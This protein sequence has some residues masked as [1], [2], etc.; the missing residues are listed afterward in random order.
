MDAARVHIILRLRPIRALPMS[1]G[2]RTA[3]RTALTHKPSN[4]ASVA[5]TGGRKGEWS[6]NS[7]IF[8]ISLIMFDVCARSRVVTSPPNCPTG[9]AKVA[10]TRATRI[11]YVSFR[12]SCTMMNTIVIWYHARACTLLPML[13]PWLPAVRVRTASF[14]CPSMGHHS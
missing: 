12:T 11:F 8:I 2:H 5:V 13:L 4:V 6:I 14:K 1:L 7:Y 10:S 9:F 3:A